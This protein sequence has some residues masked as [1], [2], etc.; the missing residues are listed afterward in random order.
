MKKIFFII[1][2]FIALLVSIFLYLSSPVFLTVLDNKIRD[3]FFKIRGPIATTNSVVIVDID[4]KSLNHLGHWPWRRDIIAKMLQNLTDAQAGIIGLDIFFPERDRK[5][6]D[7]NNSVIKTDEIFAKT[8]ENS[9]SITGF[10][11]FFD[12]NMTKG[13]LPKIP[14]FFVK[15]NFH[16]EF[17]LDAKGYLSNIKEIQKSAY[18]GGFVNMIPDS[19][20][21][22][23]YVPLLIKYKNLIYPSLAFEMFR[24]ATNT[25]K[26]IINY[27]KAG[28][29][30]IE[31]NDY[32]IP[33]DRFGRIFINYRG[34]KNTFPYI[35]AVDVI[36][37]NFDKNIVKN[38]F[39]I[40]GTSAAG[41]FDLRVT[42]YN[43]VFPGVE[44]HANIIDNLIKGDFIY[45]PDYAEVIDIFVIILVSLIVAIVIYFTDAIVSFLFIAFLVGI[46][47]L[48][49]YYLFF[50]YGI[51]IEI[52]I[53]LLIFMFL[54]LILYT[55]NYLFESKKAKVLKK[56]F[57]KKVSPHVLQE[58]IKYQN[59]AL[60]PKVKEV[61][62]FFSDIWNFTSIAEKIGDPK[63]VIDILNI[64]FDPI[65]EII[66][67]HRGTIDKFVGDAVMAYWNAP[68]DVENHA[69]EA[70]S[71]AVEQISNLKNINKKIK[72]KYG[73][74][75]NIGIGIN[76]GV[77]TIG[78]MGSSGRSD[79]T[80]IGDNVNLA[81]RL[82]GLTR[83]YKTNIII[84]EFTKKLLK[85]EYIIR[86]LDLVKVKGK[87][88]PVRI[89]EVLGFGKKEFKEYEKALKL[90]R[91]GNF[92]EA[93]K[94]FNKLYEKE[95]D[96]L[97]EMYINRCKNL[98]KNKPQNFDG[99][100]IFN[101]K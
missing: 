97:Y 28:V 94:I 64:Y 51:I 89:F 4:E 36:K 58:L 96:E 12:K 100:Y 24:I 92:E 9:P 20:G 67:K 77:V 45:K 69:D 19:D 65:A 72:N 83:I 7:N 43:S 80:I 38:K 99:I 101:E 29:D 78:E 68:I 81:S 14:A 91:A 17:L 62:V 22:V 44:V 30:D 82:Q 79:Y 66:I 85:K 95:K 34:D 1:F 26:V 53:P 10:L 13:V 32:K 18:S 54:S 73:I 52:V 16:K 98:I 23:R 56:A 41:L 87:E 5:I 59:D 75:I 86:E 40:I 93:L 3:M 8:L 47:L 35:S 21:A 50:S 90:Y 70:V 11:F 6:F 48:I 33:T 2:T 71:S 55:A 88:K 60:A 49:S 37:N 25:N 27:S 63:K 57:E 42:P 46:F 84:S 74:E 15:R 76:S 39:V 31:I 61:T